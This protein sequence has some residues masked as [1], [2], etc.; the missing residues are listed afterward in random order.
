MASTA[1][2][3]DEVDDFLI[4]DQ[5]MLKVGGGVGAASKAAPVQRYNAEW[6][7]AVRYDKIL[8][9]REVSLFS[10]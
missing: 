8:N 5:S 10:V 1:P 7:V 3:V 6:K 2:E 9:T 4:I